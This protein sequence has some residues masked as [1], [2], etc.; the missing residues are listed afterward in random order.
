MSVYTDATEYSRFESSR[1][2]I[3]VFVSITGA[4][5]GDILTLNLVRMDGY[6]SVLAQSITLSAGQT[7]CQTTFDLADAIDSDGYNVARH[8][9]YTVQ[10]SGTGL[11]LTY[12]SPEFQVS[13][14]TVDEMK[15]IWLGGVNLYS[16]S[17]VGVMRQPSAVTGVQVTRVPTSHMKGNFTLVYDS[18]PPQTLSWNGGAPITVPAGVSSLI[19]TEENGSDYIEVRVSSFLLPAAATQETL[20]VDDKPFRDDSIQGLVD[21]AQNFV[22]QKVWFYAEP[23]YDATD[24]NTLAEGPESAVFTG[25]ADVPPDVPQ[26]YYRPKDFMRWMT[27]RLPKN[28][29]LKVHNLTGYFNSTLTLDITL[30]WIVWNKLN[31]EL[32]LVP[33]NGAVVTWQFYESAMLQFLYIY[34]SI[35]SFWHFW[36]TCGLEDLRGEFSVV[37]EA[38]AKKAAVDIIHQAGL[39]YSGG[40][41]GMRISRDQVQED[42][43]YEQGFPG[44]HLADNYSQWLFGDPKTGR[45]SN[46]ISI[47]KRFV[48]VDLVVI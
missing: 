14:I 2:T 24:P 10:A 46:L 19:L 15:N 7:L 42:V 40:L 5:A 39:S 45:N 31:G 22:E 3:T 6:G 16:N 36:I 26:T 34:N 11:A 29:I 28:R 44:K 4:N 27:M 41:S 35:P 32:E 47:R 12:L 13:I 48:G 30:D 21:Y 9:L 25:W 33:S 20:T 38:I 1:D 43:R 37:R 18:G 8:G 17:M 23:T